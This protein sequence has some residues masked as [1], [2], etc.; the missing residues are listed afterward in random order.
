[1]SA[2]TTSRTIP[3]GAG[4]FDDPNYRYKRRMCDVRTTGKGKNTKTVIS[5]FAELCSDIYSRPK[6]LAHFLKQKLGAQV[7]CDGVTDEWYIKG[8]VSRGDLEL[9]VDEF[10]DTYIICFQC[11][12]PETMLRVSKKNDQDLK[13]RCAACGCDEIIPD[14]YSLCKVLKKK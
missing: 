4:N 8:D 2:S 3:L 5:N 10:I 7:S 6:H 12:S 11:G 14:K 13:R 9:L 1:M